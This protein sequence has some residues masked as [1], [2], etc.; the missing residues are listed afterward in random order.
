MLRLITEGNNYKTY[1]YT[2]VIDVQQ[3][4][5]EIE[6]EI[7]KEVYVGVYENT[8]MLIV[9]WNHEFLQK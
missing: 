8:N 4:K 2:G 7:G 1:S 5:K 3:F 6:E 9:T